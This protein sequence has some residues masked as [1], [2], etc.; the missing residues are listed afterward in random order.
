[1]SSPAPA[2]GGSAVILPARAADLPVIYRISGDC[3]PVPWPVDE[4]ARELERPHATMRVLRPF[5]GA[6]VVAFLNHWRL[7][8]EIQIMNVATD[9]GHRRRGYG[10]ALIR[11]AERVARRQGLSAV[12]LEVRASNAG[13]IGLYER[14]GYRPVGVR[15]GY[16]S[17]NGEDALV[18]VLTL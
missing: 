3:F 10:S 4:L 7:G 11:D 5:S 12:T 18:M 13:A 14:G 9:P 17:D 1:M 8:N 2:P 15:Q 16:Y 6:P